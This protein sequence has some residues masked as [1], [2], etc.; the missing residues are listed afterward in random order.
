MT[1][2]SNGT[3]PPGILPGY[4]LYCTWEYLSTIPTKERPLHTLVIPWDSNAY[5]LVV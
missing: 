4:D 1:G 5:S 2:D 3:C